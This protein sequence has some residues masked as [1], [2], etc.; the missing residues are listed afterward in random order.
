MEVFVRN[1]VNTMT[2]RQLRNTIEPYCN[3]LGIYTFA[4]EKQPN[5]PWARLTF[6][7]VSVGGRFLQKHGQIQPGREGFNRVTVKVRLF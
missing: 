7:D 4:V 6:I 5:K 2:E 3:N 1:L